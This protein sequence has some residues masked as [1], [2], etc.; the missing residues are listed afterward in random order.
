[1]PDN[2]YLDVLKENVLNLDFIGVKKVAEDAMK[3]GVPPVRAITD[4]LAAGI[5]IVGERFER[6]EYFLS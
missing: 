3:A 5:K 6:K 1:M 2:A 4:G